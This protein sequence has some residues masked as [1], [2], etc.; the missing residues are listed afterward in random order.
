ML[1]PQQADAAEESDG[2]DAAGQPA[3]AS[4][5][6]A[7]TGSV[8]VTATAAAS[9]VPVTIASTGTK[10]APATTAQSAAASSLTGTRTPAPGSGDSGAAVVATPVLPAAAISSA[11][12]L[13]TDADDKAGEADT[14]TEKRIRNLQKKLR[15]I[16]QLKVS[17]CPSLRHAGRQAAGGGGGRIRNFVFEPLE[18]C[19]WCFLVSSADLRQSHMFMSGQASRWGGTAAKPGIAGP[20]R[21]LAVSL[22]P[23]P[24]CPPCPTLT[25]ALQP[26]YRSWKSSL[27]SLTSWWRSA[28]WKRRDRRNPHDHRTLQALK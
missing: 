14:D 5:K 7:P 2:E 23:Q 4:S 19:S 15:Q 8:T 24:C 6:C 27:R 1:V 22:T 9:K 25:L 20:F 26:C 3:V 21:R 12:K 10:G 17:P 28:A 13:E 16:D 11:V 18:C